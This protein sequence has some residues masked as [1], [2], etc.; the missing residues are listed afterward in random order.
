MK[1]VNHFWAKVLI[2]YIWSRQRKKSLLCENDYPCSWC[3]VTQ[4]LPLLLLNS[5]PAVSSSHWDRIIG[6]LDTGCSPFEGCNNWSVE[7]LFLFIFFPPV[8][9][10]NGMSYWGLLLTWTQRG[11]CTA[12]RTVNSSAVS[13]IS[14]SATFHCMWLLYI[15]AQDGKEQICAKMWKKMQILS[16]LWKMTAV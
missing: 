4:F 11:A 16:S 6:W 14:L 15:L 1:T 5:L 7:R 8:V 9:C 2:H 13:N 12:D 10:N 3:P